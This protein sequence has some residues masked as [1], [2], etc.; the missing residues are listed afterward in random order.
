MA[1]DFESLNP[2]SCLDS[3]GLVRPFE[4]D[5]M[6]WHLKNKKPGVTT[7]P[8]CSESP[9]VLLTLRVLEA[10]TSAGS[11]V[12]LTLHHTWIASQK[13]CGL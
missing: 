9:S 13:S 12:L 4:A 6:A 3:C 7:K 1:G 2:V 8:Y 11:S 10:T 5:S